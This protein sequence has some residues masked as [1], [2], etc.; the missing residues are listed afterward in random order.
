MER[1]P[2]TDP[3]PH[4]QSDNTRRAESASSLFGHESPTNPTL[5]YI[6]LHEVRAHYRL[7]ELLARSQDLI[8]V[9]VL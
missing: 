1:C 5:D 4:V 6:S 2:E 8:F 7:T 9:C 3:A